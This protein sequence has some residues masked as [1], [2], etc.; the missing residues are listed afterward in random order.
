ML[1]KFAPFP[2]GLGAAGLPAVVM[3]PPLPGA[4]NPSTG[5]PGTSVTMTGSGFGS[6]TGTIAIHGQA[7]TVTLWSDTSVTFTVPT[8]A[9]YPDASP[10]VLTTAGGRTESSH[11]FTTTAPN[12]AI[13]NVSVSTAFPG[14]SIT[15]TG[16]NFGAAQG[17][18]SVTFHGIA[19]TVTAWS[20]TSITVTVPA[21]TTYPDVANLFVN[22]GVGLQSGGWVFTTTGGAIH[23]SGGA[24]RA[25]ELA[26]ALFAPTTSGMTIAFWFR[27]TADSGANETMASLSSNGTAGWKAQW[28]TGTNVVRFV[29]VNNGGTPYNSPSVAVALNGWHLF[30]G[31]NTNTGL[32]A[33]NLPYISLDG[34]AKTAGANATAGPMT[35]GTNKLA[36]GYDCLGAGTQATIDIARVGY[37][38][39]VISD[40]EITTLYNAG[41]SKKYSGLAG[42]LLTSLAGFWDAQDITGQD[43]SDSSGGGRNLAGKN[44]AATYTVVAGPP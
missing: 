31:A 27:V 41:V 14:A 19:G 1:N 2:W 34:A 13:T 12:P 37:W 29:A 39:K 24:N 35:T 16:T 30:V 11:T 4:M 32:D 38:N 10:V 5:T 25:A 15:I 3:Y 42:S 33:T 21:Q 7:G 18:G 40:A 26:S 28:V 20:D 44:G 9:S 36:I 8:Q 23:F 22:S 17:T 43:V 6:M